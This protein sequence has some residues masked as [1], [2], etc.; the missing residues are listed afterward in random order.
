M[1]SQIAKLRYATQIWNSSLQ[2]AVPKTPDNTR[3]I[4]LRSFLILYKFSLLKLDVGT[5]GA[6]NYLLSKG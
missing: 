3:N 5:M 2:A 6:C 1:Y 4:L